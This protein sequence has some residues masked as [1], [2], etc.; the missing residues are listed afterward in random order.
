MIGGI[1]RFV[2][3]LRLVWM[4]EHDRLLTVGPEL[5]ADQPRVMPP[6][7]EELRVGPAL[8]GLPVFDDQDLVVDGGL[9]GRLVDLFER[10]VRARQR[11][12]LTDGAGENRR[13]L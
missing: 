6:P 10:G 11:D 2:P 13:L 1:V 9:L 5:R 12:V 8:D 4:S 7:P 3:A